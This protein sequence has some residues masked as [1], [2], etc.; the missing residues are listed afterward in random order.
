MW[1]LTQL[2]NPPILQPTQSNKKNDLLVDFLINNYKAILGSTPPLPN[3]SMNKY[4]SPSELT[5]IFEQWKQMLNQPLD[6]CTNFLNIDGHIQVTGAF[7]AG[8][9]RRVHSG[10]SVFVQVR[11]IYS[12]FNSFV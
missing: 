1:A 11:A 6:L 5:S 10:D 8:S 7:L 9:D 2:F 12:I 3:N 4:F